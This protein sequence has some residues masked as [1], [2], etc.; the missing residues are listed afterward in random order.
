MQIHHFHAETG[1]YL[2]ES[3]ADESPLEP[4]VFHI[5]AH[6]TKDAPPA[7]RAGF[8]REFKG[9]AWGE[10]DEAAEATAKAAA[11]ATAAAAKAAEV[12]AY[13]ATQEGINVA[14][15]AELAALDAASIRS[16][17]E[18]IAA[19]PTAPQILKDKE[20]AALAARAKIK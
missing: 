19:Q 20:A 6:A 17:R 18:W 8:R 10:V 14:A 7:Q 13:N 5:S 9:G 1:A 15:K 16:I 4:G 2:G 12:A 11:D 3:T